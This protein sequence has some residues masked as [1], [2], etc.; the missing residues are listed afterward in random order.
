MHRPGIASVEGDTIW[1]RGTTFEEIEAY[2]R[3]VLIAAVERA[4]Q[5]ERER[6]G[7]QSK[8]AEQKREFES[9]FRKK[10]REAAER[11]KFNQ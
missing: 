10:A 8:Q 2:H 9:E 3:P 6:L 4:N 5:Q 7:E 1:L 11:I